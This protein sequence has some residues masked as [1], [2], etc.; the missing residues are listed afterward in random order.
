VE[1]RR[2]HALDR[3]DQSLF[4]FLGG[5]DLSTRRRRGGLLLVESLG[6][7]GALLAAPDVN[8]LGATQ[9]SYVWTGTNF[10]GLGSPDYQLG[11]AQSFPVD[12]E[13]G[14]STTTF[15]DWTQYTGILPRAADRIE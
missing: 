5:A 7:A 10:D 14:I 4:H 15:D 9:A 11:T 1:G 3:R 6:R 13:I 12:S 2:V 8:E